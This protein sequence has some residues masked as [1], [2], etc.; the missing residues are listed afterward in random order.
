MKRNKTIAALTLLIALG[1]ITVSC[2][3]EQCVKHQKAQLTTVQVKDGGDDDEDPV[4]RGKVKKNSLEVD[5]AYV[6]TMTYLTNLRVGAVYTD[7]NGDF[8]QRVE[9][10]VYYF[11]VTLPGY[12]TP[13]ITDTVHVNN[14]IQ[15]N[16]TIN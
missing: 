11:K 13:Y 1:A 6:E 16:I 7:E 9:K 2:K 10:G 12:S 3:K 8:E 14:D 4:I 5:S 15:V